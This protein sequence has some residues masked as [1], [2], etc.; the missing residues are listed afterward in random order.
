ML[1]LLSLIRVWLLAVG[2]SSTLLWVLVLAL[3]C[4]SCRV[5]KRVQCRRKIRSTGVQAQMPTMLHLKG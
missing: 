5:A 1:A 4:K 2:G 3:V